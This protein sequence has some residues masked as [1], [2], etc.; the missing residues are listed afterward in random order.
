MLGVL[1]GVV[2]GD[3]SKIDEALGCE[4]GSQ[5]ALFF[6]SLALFGV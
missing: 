3:I 2:S 5:V 1:S 4:A 6:C